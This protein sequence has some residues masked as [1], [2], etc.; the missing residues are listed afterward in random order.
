M[1]A[2]TVIE[3]WFNELTP[4]QWWQVDTNLDADI[5]ARF[6]SL[7]LAAQQ[8][9]LSH[10]RQTPEGSLAEI[11]VLDQF[12]RNMYRGTPQAFA[13]DGLALALAQ[14]AI[15]KGYDT[16]LE[17]LQRSFLY[18][19]FMHSESAKIHVQALSLFTSLGNENN[20]DFEIKHKAIIDRF[21]RYPHRNQILGRVS[22]AE[23]EAFLTQPNSS[24]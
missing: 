22:T 7:H 17:P 9:E 18:M 16:Q 5:L 23:E 6:S 19:P 15:E 24:F 11:I 4:A 3:F 10:W 1:N 8:G 12:S 13:S 21:G 20:L 14:F 2:N